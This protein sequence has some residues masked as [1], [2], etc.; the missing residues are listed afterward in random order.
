VACLI[1]NAQVWK[2]KENVVNKC[3]RKMAVTQNVCESMEPKPGYY[4]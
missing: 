1:E 2:W 3:S 4:V